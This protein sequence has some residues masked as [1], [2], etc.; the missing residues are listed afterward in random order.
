MHLCKLLLNNLINRVGDQ[1][2]SKRKVNPIKIK[3]R[4]ADP[5]P[6]IKTYEPVDIA[7]CEA[8]VIDG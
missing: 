5:A 4:K 6:E 8:E 7:E 2:P 3:K 1:S